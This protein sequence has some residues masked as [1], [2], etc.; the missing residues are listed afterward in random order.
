MSVRKNDFE[1]WGVEALWERSLSDDLSLSRAVRNA[2]MLTRFVPACLVA[3]YGSTT[4]AALW[5]FARRQFIITRIYS[6]RMWWFALLGSMFSVV[7]LWGGI[8]LAIWAMATRPAFWWVSAVAGVMFL[9][10]QVCRTLLRQE[11]VVRLLPNDRDAM[12]TARWA[13]W[14]GFWAWGLLMLAVIVS[15][16]WGRTIA[17]RGIR[18]RIKAPLKIE[19]IGRV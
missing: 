11:L 4:W 17:W 19:V 6:P 12:R 3:S 9:G 8:G 7:G 18:Y 14:L 10:C 1:R 15:S 2:K 5:E 16:A 13:D